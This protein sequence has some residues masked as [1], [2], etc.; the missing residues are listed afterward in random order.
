MAKVPPEPPHEG[1]L[2]I[3]ATLKPDSSPKLTPKPTEEDLTF[4]VPFNPNSF[5][6]TT[7]INYN[8]PKAKG[9]EGGDPTFQDIP[10]MEFNIEFTIDGSGVARSG[11][12]NDKYVRDQIRKFREVTGSNINGKIHRP[13][14]LT[15]LWG[16]IHIDCVL[17]SLNIVYTL[18]ARDGVPLRAKVTCGFIER[19]SSR[20]T[21]ADMRLESADLTTIFTIEEGDTIP[22]IAY[23]K[24]EDASYYFQLA[25]VNKM[26][27][28]RRVAP[29][30]KIILPPMI[31]ADE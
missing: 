28:F 21:N 19:I 23:E 13:N 3:I 31:E 27:S 12:A 25:R 15:L 30:S 7:K 10:P 5:T 6:I 11:T 26:K 18:F 2:K 24:Y 29:G 4:T 20:K 22:L 14:Y 16:T 1:N 8:P 9:Q 17:T